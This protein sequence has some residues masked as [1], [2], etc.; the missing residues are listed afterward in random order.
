VDLGDGGRF[1]GVLTGGNG[2]PPG[3]GQVNYYGFDVGPGHSSI[4]AD[5]NLQND[6][7][8]TVGAYLVAPDGTA[9]GFGQNSVNGVNTPSITAY[10][11]NPV[12][13]RWTLIVQV[14]EPVVGDEVSQTFTGNIRLDNVSVSAPSL[15]N[16]PQ[17]TLAAGV[18]VKVPV[19]ITNHGAAAGAFFVDARL[20]TL[21]QIGL[22]NLSPPPSSAGYP[23]PLAGAGPLWVV[24]TQTSSVQVVGNSTVP[25][26]FD[27]GPNQGDPDLVAGPT[28]GTQAA[29]QFVPAGG[30]VQQGVWFADPDEFGPFSGPA[31]TGLANFTFTA[32]TKAFD[33]AVTSAPGDLWLAAVTPA[34]LA[35]FAPVVI[36]PGQT[37]TLNVTITPS[38]TSG[39][40]VSGNL[41]VDTAQSAVPP[42]GQMTG[43]ELAAIP[44]TYTIK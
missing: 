23:L 19:R 38:G 17:T 7:G 34:T 15:P 33:P 10:T 18:P 44:Y 11:H 6:I 13:G 9:L 28:T 42:Y 4:T 26:E 1:Q 39:T 16:S 35:S 36:E 29:G 40:V 22:G 21:T 20:N 24:P 8:D 2:R 5:I 30:L 27:Y 37:G 31:P 43:S 32:K 12:A 3:E 41:Y 14:A 25:I